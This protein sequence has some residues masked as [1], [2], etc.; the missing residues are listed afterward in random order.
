MRRLEVAH[1][2]ACEAQLVL[3]DVGQQVRVLAAVDAVHLVKCTHS[4]A[5]VTVLHRQRERQ[6][7]DLLQRALVE[8]RVDVEAVLLLRVH[9]IVLGGGHHGVALDTLDRANGHLPR[10]DRIFSQ[11]LEQ[12]A[13]HGDAGDIQARSQ[14][15]VVPGRLRFAAQQLAI[16][17]GGCEVPRR[18]QRD[19]R[20]K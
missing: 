11:G 3:E 5:D 15:D 16:L 4:R 1:H 19:G 18:R 9:V 7:V 12:A 14:E 17:P 13:V 2:P 6:R 8:L 20:R 10:Q